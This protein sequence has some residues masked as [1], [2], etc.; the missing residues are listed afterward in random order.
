MLKI[1]SNDF[2][3]LIKLIFDIIDFNFDG[4]ITQ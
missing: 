3:L 4:I 2:D 1:Y